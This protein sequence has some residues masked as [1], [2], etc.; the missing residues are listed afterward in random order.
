MDEAGPRNG[1]RYRDQKIGRH[2]VQRVE[3]LHN[4]EVCFFA[5][6]LLAVFET[7]ISEDLLVESH[8]QRQ[9]L[10]LR[11][12]LHVGV[13]AAL[14]RSVVVAVQRQDVFRLLKSGEARLDV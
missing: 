7:L 4:D 13:V 6:G 8:P 10:V 2:L 5:L 1:L 11:L 3:R 12:H 14:P 9:T